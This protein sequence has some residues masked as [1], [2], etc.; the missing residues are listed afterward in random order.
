MLKG[1]VLISLL[2][3]VWGSTDSI[4]PVDQAEDLVNWFTNISKFVFIYYP[5][6]QKTRVVVAKKQSYIHG[7]SFKYL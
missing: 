3:V 7:N 2:L 1:F 5:F 6:S 4:D